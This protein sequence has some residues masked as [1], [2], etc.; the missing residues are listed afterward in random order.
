MSLGF[1]LLRVGYAGTSEA[2][3]FFTRPA[4]VLAQVGLVTDCT[5]TI[6]C[7]PRRPAATAGRA[8]PCCV[9]A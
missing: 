5:P 9:V 6:H 3:G 1:D 2:L 4:I 7:R 8:Q